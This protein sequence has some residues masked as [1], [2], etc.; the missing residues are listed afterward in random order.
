M[1]TDG[2]AT[3]HIGALGVLGFVFILIWG[4]IALIAAAA[5]LAAV[6]LIMFLL[7]RLRA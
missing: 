7:A 6:F 3:L 5:L 2:E 4:P 1:T